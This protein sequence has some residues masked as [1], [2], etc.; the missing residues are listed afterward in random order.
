MEAQP[1]RHSK[2]GDLA[3]EVIQ[4]AQ[5]LVGLEIALA[6]QELKDLAI[7]NAIAAGMVVLGGLLVVL[8]VLVAVPSMIV[9]L[10]PWHWQAAAAWIALYV[11]LGIGLAFLGKARF[12]VKLPTKTLKSL[13]E[14]K[15]WAL[16]RMKSIVR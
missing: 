3:V 14:S 6:K 16:R 5:R 2:S 13:K 12:R 4:D 7:T 8:G 11:L 9:I 10:V 15:E 1:S